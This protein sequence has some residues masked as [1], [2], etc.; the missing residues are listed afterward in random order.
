MIKAAIRHSSWAMAKPVMLLAS[1]GTIIL[2]TTAAN[3]MWIKLCTAEASPRLCGKQSIAR[4]LR[5]GIDIAIP[6]AYS[7]C[8]AINPVMVVS[9]QNAR[10]T[11]IRLARAMDANARCTICRVGQ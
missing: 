3:K 1:M 6:N 2:A 4:M 10:L 8:G 11:L 5:A 9:N 7:T